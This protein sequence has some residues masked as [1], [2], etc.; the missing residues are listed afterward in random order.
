MALDYDIIT[1]SWLGDALMGA[2]LDQGHT[3]R[4]NS[5][6]PTALGENTRVAGSH[7]G[8]RAADMSSPV[9]TTRRKSTTTVENSG[10]SKKRNKPTLNCLECVERKSKCDRGRPSCFT[11]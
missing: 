10:R 8:G 4:G 2:P 5:S 6:S 7:R 11:W 9:G 3:P 1:A